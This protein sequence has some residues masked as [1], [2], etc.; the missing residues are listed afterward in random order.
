MNQRLQKKC[1]IASAGFHLLLLVILFVGPAFL[2]SND[3]AEDLQVLTVIP[4]LAVEGNVNGGGN[5][6][7]APPTPAPRNPPQTPQP[8][9]RIPE[10]EPE[11]A[12]KPPK[13]E[14]D[15]VPAP[16]N[17]PKKP[18]ISLVEKVRKPSNA[19][20]RNTTSRSSSSS[21]SDSTARHAFNSSLNNLRANLSPGTVV[22][23]NP[24]PGGGGPA[25]AGYKQII[26]SIYYQAWVVPEESDAN[27]ATAVVSVTISRDGTIVSAK[28]TRSSGNAAVDRTVQAALDR[29]PS[30]PPFPEGAKE[31][32]RTFTINFN[33]KARQALG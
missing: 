17:K 20:N 4:S 6:H 11:Q 22:D 18:Q 24:G 10:P 32:R 27:T 2:S 26:G 12:V 5:P 14:P 29:V 33:L 30:V 8:A 1:L 28:I 19:T 16:G 7:A 15:D 3:K 31:E 25:Y 13:P 9:P 21:E 23:T